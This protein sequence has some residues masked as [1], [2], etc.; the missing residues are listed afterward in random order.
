MSLTFY[1]R[2]L[3]EACTAVLLKELSEILYNEEKI[4][5]II[6]K[7]ILLRLLIQLFIIFLKKYCLG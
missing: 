3:D 6:F 5:N 4:K 1:H 7:Q 2:V